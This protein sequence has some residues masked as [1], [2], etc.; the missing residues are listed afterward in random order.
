MPFV[1]KALFQSPIGSSQH[2]PDPLAAPSLEP[3]FGL[4]FCPWA[5]VLVQFKTFLL[6]PPIF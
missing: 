2:S 4:D 3:H 1:T 5:L 6:K